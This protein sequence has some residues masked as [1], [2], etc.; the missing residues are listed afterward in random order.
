MSVGVDIDQAIRAILLG[1]HATMVRWFMRLMTCEDPLV[2]TTS[3]VVAMQML[4]QKHEQ[5]CQAECVSIM[6][7]CCLSFLHTERSREN[8]IV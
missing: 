5:L 1:V 8:G 3:N 6:C 7:V 4:E 2:P